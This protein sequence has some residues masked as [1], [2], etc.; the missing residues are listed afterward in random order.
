MS[1]CYLQSSVVDVSTRKLRY[2]VAVADE[3]NFSRAAA[4]LFVAQQA[5]S[6]QIR[7][8]EGD[9]GAQLLTR[10]TRSVGLT[11]AGVVFLSTAREAL[12]TIDAGVDAARRVAQGDVGILRLGFLVGGAMELMEPIVTAF[13]AT[14]PGIHIQL[15]EFGFDDPSAGLADGSSDVAILRPPLSAADIELEPLFVEPLVVGI[16]ASHR[17]A[18][19][20]SVSVHE[21]LAEPLV[22]ARTPDELW[23]RM[24]TLEDYRGGT[25]APIVALTSSHTE[26]LALVASGVGATVTVA[27]A[28]RYTPQFGVRYIPIDDVAG[29][30]VA[31]G[32]V[33]GKRTPLVER[34][35][36]TVFEVRD[37]ET[38]LVAAIEHPFEERQNKRARS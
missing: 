16:A 6:K 10:T 34:F 12:A 32:W 2:F 4:R 7:E 27:A 5:V 38:D 3:L 8:L 29:S 33:K 35:V 17:L 30:V 37:R 9:V 23:R 25:R 13:G 22:V 1:I 19:R 21:L 26:E 28:S 20:D 36:K 31:I 11:P 15:R 18:Q 14:N 24:W